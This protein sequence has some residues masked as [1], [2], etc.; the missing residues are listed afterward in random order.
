MSGADKRLWKPERNEKFHREGFL[1]A[2]ASRQLEI[3]KSSRVS[4]AAATVP[5][6]RL[7][8]ARQLE[9]LPPAV[10]HYRRASTSR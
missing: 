1:F 9:G 5:F 4:Q 6:S 8:L 3:A 10:V 2:L 7:L